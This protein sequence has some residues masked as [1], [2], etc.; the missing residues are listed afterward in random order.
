MFLYSIV[1]AILLGF[2]FKGNLKNLGNINLS[3]L[4]L[5]FIGYALDE[6]MHLMIKGGHLKVGTGTYFTDLLM[7][8]LLF[9]F[10]YMNRKDFFV[11]IIGVGFLFNAVAI[12]SNGGAMPVS[13]SAIAY[14]S[15][16]HINPAA[17]GL[18]CLLGPDTKFWFFSDIY[19]VKALG[20]VVFSL[21]DIILS[22]G[23]ILIIIKGMR[24]KYN[25]KDIPLNS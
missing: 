12:L 7:Y 11:L 19:S 1:L 13:P 4:Y 21:G 14:V 9:I 15:S 8:V 17:Q 10:I 6:I 20:H 16:T 3:S 2:I 22:I 5:V 24:G 18:Y 25:K 23:I